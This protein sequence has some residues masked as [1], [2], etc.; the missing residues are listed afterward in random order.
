MYF[1]M[2]S[3]LK[4]NCYHTAKHTRRPELFCVQR[5]IIEIATIIFEIQ[6]S[7]CDMPWYL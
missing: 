3:Y 5:I 4:S 6:F 1:G 2:K 7:N